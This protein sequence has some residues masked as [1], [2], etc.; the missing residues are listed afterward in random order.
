MSERTV[1]VRRA[2]RL[3]LR[4]RLRVIK[5]WA[6]HPE[7][8]PSAIASLFGITRAQARYI[9]RQEQEGRLANVKIPGLGRRTKS[10]IQLRH[11]A[12]TMDV[13]AVLEQQLRL[14]L[15][16]LNAMTSM[17]LPERIERLQQLV[18]MRR[19]LLQMRLQS[20]LRRLDADIIAALIRRYDPDA[21]DADIV[22][23]YHETTELLRYAQ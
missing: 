18:A 11:D 15:A 12:D 1:N 5:Y 22:R 23:I 3:A 6:K 9:L 10:S 19:S 8:G 7:L 17:I 21:T 2:R 16:E 14:C 20:H 4:E 13:D